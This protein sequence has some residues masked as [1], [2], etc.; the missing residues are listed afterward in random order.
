MR[1]WTTQD[2]PDREQYAYWRE[3]ICRAYT[4]LD[5]VT[6]ARGS[7]ESTV[8]ASDIAG[9]TIS[10]TMSRAQTVIRGGNE[11]RRLMSEE[12]YVIL[13]LAGNCGV[14][15]HKRETLISPG[16]FVMIDAAERFTLDFDNFNILVFSIPHSRILPLIGSAHD[17]VAVRRFADG[18]IGSVTRSYMQSLKGASEAWSDQVKEVT[19]SHLLNL[20]ALSFGS[21]PAAEERGRESVKQGQ[22]LAIDRFIDSSLADPHLSVTTIVERFHLSPRSLL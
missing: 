18:G 2:V 9:L 8:T 5:P 20:L 19:T 14:T 6:R 22:K 10:E 16:E 12:F 21:S 7:F 15:Q 11:I 13:Q 3:V 1:S 4:V 17:A